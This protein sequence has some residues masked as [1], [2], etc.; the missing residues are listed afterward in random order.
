MKSMKGKTKG[1]QQTYFPQLEDLRDVLF[2]LTRQELR[3]AGLKRG[4]AIKG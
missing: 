3:G 2:V 4:A 1:G